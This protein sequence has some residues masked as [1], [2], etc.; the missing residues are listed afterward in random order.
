MHQLRIGGK[1]KANLDEILS[2]IYE[3]NISTK[4]ILQ[5]YEEIDAY[6]QGRHKTLSS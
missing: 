3:V 1:R 2:K 6:S 5:K 4:E